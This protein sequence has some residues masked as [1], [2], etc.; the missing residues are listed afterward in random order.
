MSKRDERKETG[1]KSS[2]SKNTN[3]NRVTK[4]KEFMRVSKYILSYR[5]K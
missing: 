5:E 4:E 1:L 2:L 3:I